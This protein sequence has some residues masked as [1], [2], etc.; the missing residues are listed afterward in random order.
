ME[1]A[2]NVMDEPAGATPEESQAEAMG[3]PNAEEQLGKAAQEVT[4]EADPDSEPW[5][6][7]DEIDK[8]LGES[9]GEG[10]EE[11]KKPFGDQIITEDEAV[12]MA[13]E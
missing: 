10:E 4:S 9:T 11:P 5:M 7:E 1:A 13:R 2:A 3:T 6:S 12:E 8:L